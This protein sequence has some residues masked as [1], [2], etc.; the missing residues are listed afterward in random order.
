MR[1]LLTLIPFVVIVVL[2]LPVAGQEI[3]TLRRELDQMR[4][5]FQRAQQDYQQALE[6]MTERLRRLEESTPPATV[7][8]P[9]RDAAGTSEP[10]LMD[11]ARPREPFAL[12]TTRGAGVLLFDI[13]VAGDFVGNLVQDRVDRANVGTFARRENRFFARELE[14][15]LFGQ[16]DPYAR[17]EV[18]VVSS[19]LSSDFDIAQLAEAHLTLPT[20]PLGVQVKLGKVRNRFGLLNERHDHDLPQIDRPDVLV[21][22]FGENG[23]V[24][25]GLEASIAADLPFRLEALVGVF[26]GDNDLAFG[27]QSLR[28]PLLTARLRTLLELGGPS[29]IQLGVSG[30]NGPTSRGFD[31]VRLD[32]RR[33]TIVGADL[34]YTYT[35]ENWRHPL[36]T[37]A[38]ETV[39]GL[40][41]RPLAFG[42]PDGDGIF[43]EEQS[44]GR[45]HGWYAFVELQPWQKWLGGVRYDWTQA[46]DGR[47][48]AEWAIEPYVGFIL[49]EFLRFRLAYKHTDRS[50][51]FGS[52]EIIRSETSFDE[53]LF[54]ASFVLGAHPRR[55]Y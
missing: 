44:T 16:I 19:E 10:T 7:A 42:D 34:K 21:A 5:Q 40:A 32:S 14:L 43:T 31:G 17:A 13:G 51:R 35:P 48:G 50:R 24:E 46:T 36:L 6:V 3:D 18:R 53:V 9:P 38:G 1:K 23:L 27:R 33:N 22:F 8:R 39:W 29:V 15:N 28:D 55:P 11:L 49:S 26:N 4:Q 30:A 25:K 54:Q 45:R 41:R 12:A 52:A 2:A 20:L 47:S 37:L